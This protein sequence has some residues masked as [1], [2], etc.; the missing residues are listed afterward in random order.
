MTV[1][2]Q[3]SMMLVQEIMRYQQQHVSM[4]PIGD[5]VRRKNNKT[6]S[7]SKITSEFPN[8]VGAIKISQLVIPDADLSNSRINT[9]IENGSPIENQQQLLYSIY[10]HITQYLST[11]CFTSVDDGNRGRGM[12]V[13]NQNLQKQRRRKWRTGN[14]DQE[15]LQKEDHQQHQQNQRIVDNGNENDSNP[16]NNHGNRYR[17]HNIFSSEKHLKYFPKDNVT[18]VKIKNN[19]FHFSDYKKSIDINRGDGHIDNLNSI[20][21][22]NYHKIKSKK[23]NHYEYGINDNVDNK[24]KNDEYQT[25]R[26][27]K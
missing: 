3:H 20:K 17:R 5:L 11:E 10:H 8:K 24:I 25:N 18:I 12:K 19:T 16:G 6:T 22:S 23:E 4:F 15:K 21:K 13:R 14:R 1:H 7:R 2:P 27:M 9:N 26:M